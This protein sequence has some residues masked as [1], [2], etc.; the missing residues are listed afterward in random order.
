ML[1]LKM[2]EMMERDRG[3]ALGDQW[4]LGSREGASTPERFKVLCV[5]SVCFFF[6]K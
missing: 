3:F 5:F 1:C 6:M 2:A 4:S